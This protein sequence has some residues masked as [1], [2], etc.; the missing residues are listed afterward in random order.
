MHLFSLYTVLLA[1]VNLKQS[2]VKS[3]SK[4]KDLDPFEQL[5]INYISRVTIVDGWLWSLITDMRTI[6]IGWLS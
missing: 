4:N 3:A 1:V 2:V 6:R 5:E